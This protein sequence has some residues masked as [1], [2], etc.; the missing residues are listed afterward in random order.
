ML[1]KIRVLIQI[2][3]RNLTSNFLKTVI[4]GPI[5]LFGTF[6]FVVLNGLLDSVSATMQ[7]SII[8]S[9]SGHLQVYDSRAR[10]QLALFGDTMMGQEDIGLIPDFMTVKNEL[11]AHENVKVVVP[12]G[13][14]FAMASTGN[15]LDEMFEQLRSAATKGDDEAVA[16]LRTQLEQTAELLIPE[17]ELSRAISSEPEEID[18]NLKA[19]ERVKTDEFWSWLD[20]EPQAALTWLDTEIAPIA[21]EGG[22]F[23]LRYMGTDLD[24]YTKHFDRFHI[25]D[26]EMVPEGRRGFLFNKKFFEEGVKHKVARDLDAIKKLRDEEGKTLADDEL[27]ISRAKQ[28]AREYTRI[29][30]QLDPEES[31]HLETELREYLGEGDAG[32]L[33]DL[34]QQFLKVDDG[35]FDERY[36]WFYEHVAP[37]IKL[38]QFKVG[39]II[40]IRG[41]TQSGYVKSVNVKVYGTFSFEGLEASDLAAGHNLIDMMTFRDLYGLMTDE[42]RA[43]LDKIREGVGV[44]RIA[45]DD[46]ED[47]LFGDDTE[48]VDTDSSAGGFDEFEVADLSGAGNVQD[49]LLDVVYDSETINSGVALNAAVILENP[50]LLWPTYQEIRELVTEKD[51][52]LQV[53]DWRTASGMVGQFVVMIRLLLYVAIFIIFLVALVIINNSMVMAT[54]R[55]VGEIGTMRAIGAQ[56]RFVMGMFF[57]ETL[58][59]GLASGFLGAVLGGVALVVMG[60]VGIP[61][62]SQDILIFLFSGPRLYPDV[63]ATNFIIGFFVVLI[64]SIVSTLYPAFIATRIQPVVAMQAKE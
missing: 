24:I 56:R 7:K 61:A 49:D 10:D 35:N 36:A 5:I 44:E 1:A 31:A 43:E 8:Q 58:V 11:E 19:L 63:T 64:M 48:I 21:S 17:L 50:K 40:T 34:V 51:M 54:L 41:V 16:R 55:R 39:D 52:R 62:G 18:E 13:L 26:G 27:L 20:E 28:M 9:V 57:T 32:T 42:R 12:M 38:Y 4:V 46:V 47:A 6:L 29:T 23:F 37:L 45:R 53:V 14:D 2:A 33:N 22:M 60:N 15:E 3:L 59:L 30:L 25:V